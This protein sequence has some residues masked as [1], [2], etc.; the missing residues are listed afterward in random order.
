PYRMKTAAGE[1]YALPSMLELDDA[2]A[3][4]DR[5]FR[6]DEYCDELT[7]AFDTIYRDSEK[8]GRMMVINIHPSLMGQAVRID[9]LDDAL[10]YMMRRRGVWA[11]TG[12]EIIEAYRQ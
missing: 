10:A 1:L 11:A 7:E 3:L 2:F 8:S 4:R 12:S 6:V 5:R 9:F